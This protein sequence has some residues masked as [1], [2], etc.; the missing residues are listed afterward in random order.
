MD[1]KSL[2]LAVTKY[3]ES[4][5]LTRGVKEGLSL[6]RTASRRRYKTSGLNNRRLGKEADYVPCVV[7]TQTFADKC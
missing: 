1:E 2:D 3:K 6:K 5:T 4:R 7:Q